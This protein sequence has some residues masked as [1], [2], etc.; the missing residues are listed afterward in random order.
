MGILFSKEDRPRRPREMSLKLEAQK[1]KEF[2]GHFDSWQKWKARTEC[3]FDGSG[4]ALILTDSEYSESNMQMNRVVFAQLFV[5]TVDGTAHHLVKQHEKEKDGNAAWKALCEWYDGDV[6]KNETSETIRSRIEGLKLHTGIT[7]SD[8][9]NKYLMYYHDLAKI[10][11]EG[12]SAS[13]G[14]YLFLRNIT[15]PDYAPTV[16][17][18]RNTNP[19]LTDC[20][21]AIR[22]SERD[23]LQK[24]Q[25]SRQFK[26]TIRR[27]KIDE[28]KEKGNRKQGRYDEDSTDSESEDIR[29]KKRTKSRRVNEGN[30]GT[31]GSISIPYVNWVDLPEDQKVFVQSYNAKIKHNESV[32]DLKVPDGFVF[33]NKARRLGNVETADGT[34][35]SKIISTTGT[36]DTDNTDKVSVPRKKKIR[37]NLDQS[38]SA[39]DIE[40]IDE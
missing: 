29:P 32:K 23:C 6:I 2:T 11:G 9:V 37:F 16:S 1:V 21:T 38:E 22:K 31:K 20:V 17:F 33:P 27:M 3:A 5:A 13:H 35:D 4:Y 12:L 39:E 10:P 18:L 40:E 14:T 28:A 7:A 24:K 26:Q 34:K 8:Y 25:A 15:D 36:Q 19:D 30:F